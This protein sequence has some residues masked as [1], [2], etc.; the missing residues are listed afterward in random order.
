[1]KVPLYQLCASPSMCLVVAESGPSLYHL[2]ERNRSTYCLPLTIT[3]HL[4]SNLV[5]A[6]SCVL[7]KQESRF[8]A[9]YLAADHYDAGHFD[10]KVFINC[11]VRGD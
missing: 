9:I 8:R 10:L 5:E 2:Y 11:S 1:M 4:K 7:N 6:H 3:N